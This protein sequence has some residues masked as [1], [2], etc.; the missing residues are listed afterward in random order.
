MTKTPIT[1]ANTKVNRFSRFTIAL[2]RAELG[3]PSCLVFRA[4]SLAPLAVAIMSLYFCMVAGEWM[5]LGVMV[6]VQGTSNPLPP[7]SVSESELMLSPL[8]LSGS[9]LF[10]FLFLFLFFFSFFPSLLLLGAT[11]DEFEGDGEGHGVVGVMVVE[12][13]CRRL[14]A[15]GVFSACWTDSTWDTARVGGLGFFCRAPG[16]SSPL[17]FWILC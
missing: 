1:T 8:L 9:F 6:G 11:S 2:R 12:G 4:T 5:P 10:L 7:C 3:V 13:A 16:V 15:I 17:P 14:L